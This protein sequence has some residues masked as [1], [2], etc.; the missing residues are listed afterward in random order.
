MLLTFY[1]RSVC[2]ETSETPSPDRRHYQ[3]G[4]SCLS[5]IGK[6]LR[7]GLRKALQQPRMMP[8]WT[9]APVMQ[10]RKTLWPRHVRPLK[11]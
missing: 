8:V 7:L 4:L 11:E 10:R 5:D 6:R 2:R 3:E 9:A 1:D